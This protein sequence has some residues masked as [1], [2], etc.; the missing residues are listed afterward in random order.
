MIGWRWDEIGRKQGCWMGEQ[1]VWKGWSKASARL[2]VE[3]VEEM[4]LRTLWVGI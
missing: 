3:G 1:M 4:E 2:G